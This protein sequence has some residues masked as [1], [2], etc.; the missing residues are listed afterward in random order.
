[1]HPPGH[2]ALEGRRALGKAPTGC[3]RRAGRFKASAGR[4]ERLGAEGMRGCRVWG[5]IGVGVVRISDLS[6]LGGFKHRPKPS[7]RKNLDIPLH[8]HRKQWCVYPIKS[9]VAP[10]PLLVAF[11]RHP[12][13]EFLIGGGMFKKRAELGRAI[14]SQLLPPTKRNDVVHSGP[15]LVNQKMQNMCSRDPGFGGSLGILGS[16][17]FLEV[18]NCSLGL[19]FCPLFWLV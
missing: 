2:R 8:G 4:D 12:S 18:P 10:F 13:G 3:P 15:Y 19:A 11:Q 7:P 6:P 17:I 1:M 14:A 16:C 5:W 9:S